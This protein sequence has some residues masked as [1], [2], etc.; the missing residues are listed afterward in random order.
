M[1]A[2]VAM[3][4]IMGLDYRDFIT[5]GLLYKRLQPNPSSEGPLNLVPDNW[6]YV[7]EAGVKVGR[8]QIFNNWSPY[9]VR[10]ANTVWIGLEYFCREGD[11]LW[12]M[13]DDQLV[14]LAVKEMNLL[15]LA[16]R[17]GHTNAQGLSGVLRLV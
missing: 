8:L 9:M 15:R 1:E 12:Q 5:V 16:G 10:D 14:R 11:E 13:S 2:T 17:C 3:R 7:Q 6:I 4:L